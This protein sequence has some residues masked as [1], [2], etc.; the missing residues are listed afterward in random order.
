MGVSVLLEANAADEEQTNPHGR[1]QI[2]HD[3]PSTQSIK[4]CNQKDHRYDTQSR[5]DASVGEWIGRAR[6]LEKVDNVARFVNL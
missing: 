2:A 6:R 3:S 1:D 4:A 5:S